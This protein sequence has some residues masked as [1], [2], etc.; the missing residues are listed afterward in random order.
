MSAFVLV[1]LC[2][3]VGLNADSVLVGGYQVGRRAE[4]GG[5]EGRRLRG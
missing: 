4:T 2:V 1:S 3:R 5:H